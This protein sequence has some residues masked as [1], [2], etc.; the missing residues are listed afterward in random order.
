MSSMLEP[1]RSV[2]TAV[3]QKYRMI[4]GKQR[5]KLLRVEAALT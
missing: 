5:G 4:V 2:G 1:S 3:Q